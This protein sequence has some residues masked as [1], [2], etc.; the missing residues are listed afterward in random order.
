[1]QKYITLLRGI[2]VAGKNK[3]KM[4]ELIIHLQTLGHQ[5]LQ[6]YIQSGNIIFSS[7]ENNT[8]ILSEQIHHLILTQYG[9]DISVITIPSLEYE[10]CIAQN[11]FIENQNDPNY[12]KK[13]NLTFLSKPL[14]E[15]EIDKIGEVIT[16]TEIIEFTDNTIYQWYPHNFCSSKLANTISKIPTGTTRNWNT[17]QKIQEKLEN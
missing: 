12:L 13:L 4:A 16:D 1:M 6:T 8:K 7:D 5:N 15:K 14:T 9:Y 10:Q 3:I 11:P 2:N 17:I